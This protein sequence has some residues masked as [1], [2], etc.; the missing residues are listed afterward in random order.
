MQPDA[1]ARAWADA[2]NRRDVDAVLAHFADHVTFSSPKAVEAVGVPTVV[3]R[4]ELRRYW[5]TA[6]AKITALEFQVRRTLWDA[7]RR[8]LAIVYDRRINGARDRAL[9]LLS[10]DADGRVSSGEVFYGVL[11]RPLSP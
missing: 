4:A 6:L 1:F 11:P 3:G 2:W 5:E 7:E 10:F 9:E 8:E